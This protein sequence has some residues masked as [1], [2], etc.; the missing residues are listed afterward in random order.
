MAGSEGVAAEQSTQQLAVALADT[1]QPLADALQLLRKS[2]LAEGRAA[3][4]KEAKELMQ[5]R[6]SSQACFEESRGVVGTA[7]AIVPS[8]FVGVS[9]GADLQTLEFRPA[10]RQIAQEALGKA[11]PALRQQVGAHWDSALEMVCQNTCPPLG[12]FSEVFHRCQ[13]AGVCLCGNLRSLCKLEAQFD[14][15][16]KLQCPVV[17]KGSVGPRTL[18]K[19]GDVVVQF[20]SKDEDGSIRDTWHHIA[21]QNMNSWNVS[22]LQLERSRD[23]AHIA[24]AQPLLALRVQHGS[25]WQSSWASLAHIDLTRV[26]HMQFQQLVGSSTTITYIE[27]TRPA[28]PV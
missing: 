28:S 1:S 25:M 4:F 19:E 11:S 20:V 23:A 6:S 7:A 2:R 15:G 26:W 5:W 14:A 27:H 24:R 12:K 22:L 13:V 16:L 17:P 8:A 3:R 18:L 9:R 21:Y 10:S